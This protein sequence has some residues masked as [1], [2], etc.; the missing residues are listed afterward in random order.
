M[1]GKTWPC[2]SGTSMGTSAFFFEPQ[3]APLLNGEIRLTL[4]CWD[5]I[6][7]QMLTCFINHRHCPSN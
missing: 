6:R 1:W 4:F 7:A 3:S 5:Q 2:P